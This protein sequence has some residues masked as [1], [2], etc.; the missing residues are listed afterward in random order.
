[1]LVAEIVPLISMEKY[2]CVDSFNLALVVALL[3]LVCCSVVS[4][5]EFLAKKLMQDAYSAA[6]PAQTPP[7]LREALSVLRLQPVPG[8]FVSAHVRVLQMLSILH[9][10]VRN[11]H[12]TFECLYQIGWFLRHK[13]ID[14]LKC[15]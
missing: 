15:T 7:I 10:V 8:R 6:A 11:H 2:Q 14:L 9:L 3:R 4:H 1:M 5:W 12:R 13:C